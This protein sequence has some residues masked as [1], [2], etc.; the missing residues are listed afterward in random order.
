M[1][2]KRLRENGYQVR[3]G[4]QFSGANGDADV[5]GLPGIHIEC[6]FVERLNLR[7]AMDQSI[8]D[9]RVG[10]I[11]TVMHKKKYEDWLVTM[12]I[13]D[14]LALYKEWEVGNE[15]NAEE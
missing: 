3:R 14:F 7:D 11:P 6:K 2:A 15:S 1:L 9:A 12:R 13:D 4:Q 5:V 8:R 10:E